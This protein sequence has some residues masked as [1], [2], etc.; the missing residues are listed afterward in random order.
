VEN[1]ALPPTEQQPLP[2][3][4]PKAFEVRVNKHKTDNRKSVIKPVVSQQPETTVPIASNVDTI[5]PQSIT[6][7]T[8]ETISVSEVKSIKKSI[9]LSCR[10]RRRKRH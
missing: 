3:K 2:S 4:P 8:T 5:G 9:D 6:N 10:N 7:Q 1:N